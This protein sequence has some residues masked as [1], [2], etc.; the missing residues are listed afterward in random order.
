[1]VKIPEKSIDNAL[2]E[3]KL[4]EL[5]K[6]AKEDLDALKQKSIDNLN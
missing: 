1:M 2:T 6:E 3:A 4:E 5:V